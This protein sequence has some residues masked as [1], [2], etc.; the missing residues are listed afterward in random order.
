MFPDAWLFPTKAAPTITYGQASVTIWEWYND[1]EKNRRLGEIQD[2]MKKIAWKSPVRS[3]TGSSLPPEIHAVTARE[4]TTHFGGE[5][6]PGGLEE[7][8]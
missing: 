5:K 8:R 1:L 2:F 6:L 4:I 7:Q 3:A